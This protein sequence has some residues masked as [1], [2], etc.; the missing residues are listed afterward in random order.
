[1]RG[2]DNLQVEIL[3][4]V[5]PDQLVPLDHPIRALKPLVTRALQAIS[6]GLSSMYAKVGNLRDRVNSAYT[7][8]A[9]PVL[10]DRRPL[11]LSTISLGTWEGSLRGLGR[12]RSE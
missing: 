2:D 9:V 6:P 1:M 3:S 7:R 8:T 12:W 10:A 11:W 4:A 5:T